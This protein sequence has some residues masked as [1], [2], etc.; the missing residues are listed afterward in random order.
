[1]KTTNIPCQE[2]RVINVILFWK[3]GSS[4]TCRYL[5]KTVFFA[6]KK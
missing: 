2:K 6:S 5:L 3:K 4:E 1:M